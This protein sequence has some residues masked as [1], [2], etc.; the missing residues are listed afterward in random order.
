[1]EEE[2]ER[3]RQYRC[4]VSTTDCQTTIHIIYSFKLTFIQL[5][6]TNFVMLVEVG[7][8]EYLILEDINLKT[9]QVGARGN[10]QESGKPAN[11]VS[12][13]SSG[14]KHFYLSGL[15][16]KTC[17]VSNLGFI[18]RKFESYLNFCNQMNAKKNMEKKYT[19]VLKRQVNRISYP[20]MRV[21]CLNIW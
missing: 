19:E 5:T 2:K 12:E 9:A 4:T 16:S 14:F 21:V 18:R 8:K 15:D 3:T 17:F 6:T 11:L 20:R 7:M 13:T 10:E 1:M